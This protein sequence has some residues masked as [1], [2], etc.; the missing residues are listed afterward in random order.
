MPSLPPSGDFPKATQTKDQFH[1]KFL[2]VIAYLSGLLGA[3][4]L[5]ATARAALGVIEDPA[6]N[7]STQTIW[8]PAAAMTPRDGSEGASLEVT[9]LGANKTLVSALSFAHDVNQYAQ[10][11][12]G[13]PDGWD[14]ATGF[15]VRYVWSHGTAVTNFG[16]AWNV[17]AKAI[18]DGG[19]LDG[20]WSAAQQVNDT[21]GATNTRYQTAA[22][23]TVTPAGVAATGASV[24]F[25]FGR[26][27]TD[28]T[29]DT[30]AVPASLLGVVIKY[31]TAS[32]SDA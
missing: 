8:L 2:E 11:V 23:A 9:Q 6:K 30:L 22:T 24:V 17:R 19:G 21:G 25:E 14:E 28:A 3:D 31:Q 27:A 12:V 18:N 13:M 5:P 7:A 29:N 15:S 1:S 32:L 10:F 4:G 16:T 20:A 26:V